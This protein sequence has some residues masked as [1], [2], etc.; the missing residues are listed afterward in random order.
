MAISIR[1]LLL[2]VACCACLPAWAN[3]TL[4]DKDQAKLA[5]GNIVVHAKDAKAAH[6]KKVHAFLRI[7]AP[8]SIVFSLITDYAQL[9]EFM[10]NLAKV[11][12]L[13]ESRDGALA[14][15]FLDLPFGVH[16]RYRLKL[17]YEIKPPYW[18]MAWQKV[19]WA[20]VNSDDTIVDTR[21]YWLLEASKEHESLLYYY[22]YT[23]PGHVP[24]GLGW[25][26]DYLTKETIVE[27]LKN[28][29]ERAEEQWK[30][31]AQS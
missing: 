6:S 5:S 12:V 10:P 3:H 9:P 24:F 25:I 20:G 28:T 29:K 16:K 1:G 23:N 13:E 31:T 26:V 4:S 21:G 15:Y 7:D 18:R 2:L 11:E 22:T 19:A 17:D 8:A 30:K 14:N 27:L